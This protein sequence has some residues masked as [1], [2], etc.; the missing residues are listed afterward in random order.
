M[1]TAWAVFLKELVDALRDRKTLV[2]VLLSSVVIG[3]VILF[4]ISSMVS[5]IESRAERREI[6]VKGIEF[7]PTLRNYLERQTYTVKEAPAEIEQALRDSKL[8]DPV[9]VVPADFEKKLRDGELIHVE[10]LTASNNRSA[11]S[12]SG[13]IDALLEGFNRERTVQALAVRGV[14]AAGLKSMEVQEIDLANA[15]MRASQLTG[16]LPF[17]I[18]M[19]V[20]YGALNAALDTTAGERER[21]SLEPLL[22]NPAPHW[23]LV[24]GKWGA[25][26]LV[27]MLIAVLA[28][29]SFFPAQALLKS[30]TLR[31]MF[32]YGPKEAIAFI[33]T[34]VPFAAALSAVLMAVAIRCKS[35]KE[36]Q[37]NNTFVILAVSMLPLVTIMNPGAEKSWQLFVPGL[38]QN[39]VMS[40][41]LKGEP[42]DAQAMMF[43]VIAC[44]L[45]TV[46]CLFYISKQIQ[47]A[48]LK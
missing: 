43:P 14:P 24:L 40:R 21:G 26:A 2:S 34:L 11:Q 20:L 17:F 31:A 45:I 32:Q 15:Q 23:A 30:E 35:F 36:A 13:R 28:A 22:T 5:D 44:V 6:V 19:A 12:A 7:A 48:A 18:M 42:L 27:G 46:A 39:M 38:G 41:V 33:A 29:L 37:A 25:V 47:K 10:L 3:P 16:M 4:L 1:S 8:Q 9:V